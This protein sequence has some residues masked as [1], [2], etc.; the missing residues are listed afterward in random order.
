MN[1]R[2]MI[3]GMLLGLMI[4]AVTTGCAAPAKVEFSRADCELRSKDG[5]A[6]AVVFR[7]SFTARDM[8]SQQLI[9]LVRIYGRDNKPIRSRRQVRNGARHRRG[10]QDRDGS[11]AGSP[12]HK[13]R[14]EHSDDGD[15]A[16]AGA[17]AAQGRDGGLSHQWR[18]RGAYLVPNP[19][20]RHGADH[21]A[22]GRARPGYH[23]A[24]DATGD[25]SRCVTWI[26]NAAGRLTCPTFTHNSSG[27][28]KTKR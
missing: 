20:R 11:Q 4:A 13:N 3:G 10:L 21:A 26:D 17:S 25:S 19:D 7:S 1:R 18:M 12:V 15:G 24:R 8:D 9:Y 23:Q 27:I 22:D 28:R 6:A 16:S 5:Y 2:N 14:G